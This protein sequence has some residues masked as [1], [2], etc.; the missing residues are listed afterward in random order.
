MFVQRTTDEEQATLYAMLD[1]AA[2]IIDAVTHDWCA[3]YGTLIGAIRHEAIIPW[4]DDIDVIAPAARKEDIV[5]AFT[6]C[7]WECIQRTPFMLNAWPAR[8]ETPAKRRS[9]IPW[10]HFTIVTFEEVRGEVWFECHH[11]EQMA[12]VRRD[13]VLPTA[14]GVFGPTKIRIP[15][16]PRAILDLIFPHWDTRPTSSGLN[17]RTMKP[18]K[19]PVETASI[20]VL[21]RLGFEFPGLK[22]KRR[23]RQAARR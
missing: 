13:D 22:P 9:Q 4:D 2:A 14:Y 8:E 1:R 16:N 12:A 20:T 21:E 3:A 18:Y 6:E 19:E 7:A 15:K 10:P 17:H 11:H 23:R 5:A